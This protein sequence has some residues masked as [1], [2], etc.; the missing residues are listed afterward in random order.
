MFAPRLKSRD[1]FAR[2]GTVGFEALLVLP[3]LL[4]VIFGGIGIAD[5]VTAEQQMDEAS[6][7]AART[8][9]LTGSKKQARETLRAVLGAERA[10]KAKIYIGRVGGKEDDRA[11]TLSIPP[12]ELFEVRIELEAQHATATSFAPVRGSELL[13]GRTVMQRE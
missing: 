9:A 4:A 3:L 11:E 2:R 10:N 5:L 8:A 12:G 6:G 13:V 7:R 1:R